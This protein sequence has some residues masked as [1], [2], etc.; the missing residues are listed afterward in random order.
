MTKTLHTICA[1]VALGLVGVIHADTAVVSEDES[2]DEVVVIGTRARLDRSADDLAVPVEV[3]NAIELTRAGEIDLG[4]ALTK[5]APSFNYSRLAVGDG[6]LLNVATLRGMAPDQ[7]LVLVNGKRRHSM[8]WLRVLDGVIG[9]GTGGTD[10]RAIPTTA[11]ARVEVL[12]DGAAA[13]YGSDAIAG[14]INLE[15]KNRIGHEMSVQTGQSD[16]AGGATHGISYNGGIELAETGFL[17]VSAEWYAKDALHRNG[18]NGGHDPNY[19][20]VLIDGSSPSHDGR[21]VFFNSILPVNAVMDLY[22]FGGASKREGS[23]S[24]AYRFKFN[25]W[26]G[27]QSGD[28]TWDFVLPNFVNFHAR[29]THPVYPNG[30]LPYE[31]SELTDQSLALGVRGSVRDWDTDLSLVVGKSLFDFGVS[32]SINASI[33]ARYLELNPNATVQEIIANAGPLSGNSGGIEFTQRTINLDVRRLF[34]GDFN[35]ALAAGIESRHESYA[36]SA[37]DQASWSC[38]LPHTQNFNS[39]AVGPDGAPLE[40]VVAACGFQGY[41]G[42]SPLNAQASEESRNSHGA[43][44]ELESEFAERLTLSGALRV[45]DYSDAGAQTTGKFAA[46]FQFAENAYLR[47]AV[48][49]GFRAPSLSQ[50]R[51]NSILFVG[52]DEGLTTTYS[53]N[54]GHPIARALGVDALQHETAQNWSGGVV[55]N[56][57]STDLRVSLDVYDTA[58][59]D[60]VVRSKGI[61]CAELAACAAIDATTSAIFFNGVDTETRGVDVAASWNA[62]LAKGELEFAASF[63]TNKTR[64]T[65][66]NLPKRAPAGLTFDDYFG[67]WAADTLERGQPDGQG[68]LSTTW[69][70]EAWGSLLRLNHFGEANQ[71]P[72]DT[73]VITVEP[74]QT[75]DIAAWLERDAFEIAFGINNLFGTLPTELSK[76]HLSNVLWGVRYPTDT[77]YGLAGRFAYLRV[78]YAIGR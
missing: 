27:I 39:P 23:S 65:G 9:Y 66:R 36:Q 13:Q 10:M 61:G 42:Y 26:E 67:G 71:H 29:N 35:T 68:M 32:D 16:N 56:S 25:Y 38:G 17:N 37:G 57:R 45:E 62:S 14:V 34:E 8:A 59:D 58:I 74:D 6:A 70:R 64:I 63:H 54:E 24:G 44:V 49:T 48:S 51:F 72:L 18:G 19:Q 52:S 73:G 5:L 1:F 77:P 78:N 2:L 75:I 3:H 60:R 69:R 41:P 28:A 12:R 7:T 50:R 30:F 15:L 21:A 4:A 46:R 53:A 40:G 33:G 43:F 31:E 55:W 22:A 47:A 20:D 76:T 11:V